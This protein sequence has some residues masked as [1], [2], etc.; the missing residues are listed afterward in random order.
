MNCC[1]CFLTREQRPVQTLGPFYILL[2]FQILLRWPNR[3]RQLLI[4]Q[5]KVQDCGHHQTAYHRNVSASNSAS[6]SYSYLIELS[7]SSISSFIERVPNVIVSRYLNCIID[8]DRRAL[9]RFPHHYWIRNC[10]KNF[11]CYWGHLAA[12]TLTIVLVAI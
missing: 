5:F 11:L 6:W 9:D 7:F 3:W 10:P 4:K 12:L 1:Y 8:Q 2:H